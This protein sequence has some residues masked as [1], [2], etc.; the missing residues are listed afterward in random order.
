MAAAEQK[1]ITQFMVTSITRFEISELAHLNE[2]S[3]QDLYLSEYAVP[4]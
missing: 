2:N 3:G 4:S 1:R